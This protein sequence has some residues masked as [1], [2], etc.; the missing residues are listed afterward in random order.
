MQWAEQAVREAVSL[1]ATEA[2]RLNVIDVLANDVPQLLQQLQGRSVS[3]L[4]QQKTLATAD[5][6]QHRYEPDW[7]VKGPGLVL[8]IPGVQQMVRVGLRTVVLDVPSQD[9]ISRDNVSVKVNAVVYFRVIDPQ[10]S[11][12]QVEDFL[13]ATSQLAQTTLRAVLGKHALD[14]M[15]ARQPEAMQLRYLQ[16]LANIAGDKSNTIVFPLP[17]LRLPGRLL[18]VSDSG[19]HLRRR[20]GV[21]AELHGEGGAALG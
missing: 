4:G 7:R 18:E 13:N 11:I 19:R 12:I 14:E 6:P 3:V 8:L 20:L 5:A 9:V 21:V 10:K 17:R 16:T 1:S 15:L 2:L